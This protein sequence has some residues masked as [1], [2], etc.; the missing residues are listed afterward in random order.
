[1]AFDPSEHKAEARAQAT[2]ASAIPPIVPAFRRVR[3]AIPCCRRDARCRNPAVTVNVKYWKRKILNIVIK[4]PRT[5]GSS[6]AR[7][8][9]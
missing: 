4:T 2:V 7:G 1:M 3:G 8:G 6:A 5:L 9:S